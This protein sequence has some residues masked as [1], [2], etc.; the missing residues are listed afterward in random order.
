MGFNSAFKG[1]INCRI[2]QS[3]MRL[4]YRLEDQRFGIAFQAGNNIILFDS[5]FRPALWFHPVLYPMHIG[6]KFRG[7][8]RPKR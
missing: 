7:L 3:A 6:E 4:G 5:S 1:L 2:S 8:K